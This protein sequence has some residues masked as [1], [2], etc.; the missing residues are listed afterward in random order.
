M[1]PDNGNR[2]CT[3]DHKR[4]QVAKLLTKLTRERGGKARILNCMGLRADESPAR[5]KKLPFTRNTRATNGKRTVDDW[6][7][8]HDWTEREVWA[9]IAAG[10]M[11][12][13][14]AYDLGMPRLSC[15]FC[16]FAS[17]SALMI[18]GYHNRNLLEE[19]AGAESRM[20]HT[21]RHGFTIQSVLDRLQAGEMPPERAQHWLCA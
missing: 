7:P 6:L 12:H 15:C 1:W 16:V 18:A 11:P 21:F 3:S 2:Y 19:Y 14:Y 20:G 5:A 13:H 4:D 10:G 8:I 17:P 9:R